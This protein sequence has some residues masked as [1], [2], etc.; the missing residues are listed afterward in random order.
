MTSASALAKNVKME[1]E[2]IV[3]SNVI[4]FERKTVDGNKKCPIGIDPTRL[5][6][7]VEEVA[8]LLKLSRGLTY[9]YLRE[10]LIPSQRIGRRF[11]ISRRRLHAWLDGLAIDGEV[12]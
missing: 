11:V 4:P 3:M 2:E 10:G 8:Y 6:Y 7:T 1:A 12:G 5:T 9:Q